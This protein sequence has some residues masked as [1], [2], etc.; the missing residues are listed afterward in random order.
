MVLLVNPLTGDAPDPARREFLAEAV[1]AA[2]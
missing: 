2:C 1:E